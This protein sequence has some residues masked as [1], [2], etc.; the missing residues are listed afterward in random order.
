M[1]QKMKNKNQLSREKIDEMQTKVKT[2]FKKR[3]TD[4]LQQKYNKLFFP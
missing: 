1:S 4:V 2:Y 3:L